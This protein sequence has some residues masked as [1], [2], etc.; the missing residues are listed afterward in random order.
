MSDG[1][2]I[3]CRPGSGIIASTD[4]ITHRDGAVTLVLLVQIVL[5]DA[6]KYVGEPAPGTVTIVVAINVW[7]LC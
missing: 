3:E 4:P 6:G 5:L 7:I 1:E 2:L